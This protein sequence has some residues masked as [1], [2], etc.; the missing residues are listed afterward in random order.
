MNQFCRSIGISMPEI[1]MEVEVV[2][3]RRALAIHSPLLTV[4]QR[5]VIHS[6]LHSKDLRALPLQWPQNNH[7]IGLIRVDT[8][9][10]GEPFTV[11][12][13][14]VRAVFGAAGLRPIMGDTAIAREAGF[15]H[16]RTLPS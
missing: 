4:F 10:P 12:A 8:G 11:F 14:A 2:P 5:S 15:R 1:A 6:A 9:S 16:S 13:S 7:P 3:L